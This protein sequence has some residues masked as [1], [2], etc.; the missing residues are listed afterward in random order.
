M[1]PNDISSLFKINKSN[2]TSTQRPISR[3]GKEYSQMNTKEHYGKGKMYYPG[4]SP[5]L[6]N[7]KNIKEYCY[8]AYH[9]EPEDKHNKQSVNIYIYIYRNYGTN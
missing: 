4:I 1:L 9:R 6:P 7:K 8:T 5:G 2:K 3:M